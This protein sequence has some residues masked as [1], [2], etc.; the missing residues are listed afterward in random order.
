MYYD[1]KLQYGGV[2]SPNVTVINNQ[3][4]AFII[5]TKY[6]NNDADISSL[7]QVKPPKKVEIESFIPS[8]TLINLVNKNRR[9]PKAGLPKALKALYGV[10]PQEDMKNE[11]EIVKE[12]ITNELEGMLIS[13]VRRNPGNNEN[14][15]IS[16]KDGFTDKITL[17][18]VER[19]AIDRKKTKDVLSQLY[20][21]FNKFISEKPRKRLWG[22]IKLID[23]M[24]TLVPDYSMLSYP[25]MDFDDENSWETI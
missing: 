7:T 18:L 19:L 11:H 16:K 2:D 10:F 8:D 1:G 13:L 3:L 17:E 14:I 12:R 9:K 23:S 25:N 6:H 15:I 4:K 5:Y 24:I 21:E 22:E 20:K